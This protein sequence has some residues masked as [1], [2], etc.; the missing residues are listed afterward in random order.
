MHAWLEF[1]AQR[2]PI[3][4]SCTIGRLPE[5]QIILDDAQV[6][7]RHAL[8]Q[9]HGSGG[10]WLIDFGSSNG[11]LL[12]H[13][14]VFE[15]TRLNDKD[16][17]EIA[18]HCLIFREKREL[19]ERGAAHNAAAWKATERC[20]QTFAATKHA[21]VLLDEDGKVATITPQAREWLTVYF[22]GTKGKV[23]PEKLR[24]W[25]IQQTAIRK[26]HEASLPVELVVP[27]DQQ[28]RLVI[29]LAERNSPQQLLLLTE[30]QSIFSTELLQTLGLTA[31]ES[32]VLYWLA[33]G[34]SNPEIGIILESSPRTVGKHV[35]HI[36][37]KL[38]VESRTAALLYVV[39]KLTRAGK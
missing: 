11:S 10:H 6:S 16:E 29:R 20:T 36:F 32:E 4:T 31:R 19:A 17:I 28:R 33:E 14:R 12:N 25:L 8:V 38:G 1:K 37:Q 27:A 22:T 26:D 9:A 30:E 18:G 24:A 7:R 13:R 3:A 34:K 21:A 2:I 39:E 5:N 23:L 15:P 35:E